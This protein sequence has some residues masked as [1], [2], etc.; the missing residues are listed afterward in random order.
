[1]Q[2]VKSRLSKYIS[3]RVSCKE[4]TLNENG[5]ASLLKDFAAPKKKRGAG[6]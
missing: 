4:P 1:M 2:T 3:I 6:R 5:G